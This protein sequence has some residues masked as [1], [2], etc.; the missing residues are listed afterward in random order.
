MKPDPIVFLAGLPPFSSLPK[1]ELQKIK[2]RISEHSLAQGTTL[3]VQ[4]KTRLDRI[5]I[6]K[7]GCLQLYYEQKGHKY[8]SGL[9]LPGEIY[10][11][12][13][14]LTN[15]GIS[16]RTVIAKEHSQLTLSKKNI[17]WKSVGGLIFFTTILSRFSVSGCS[18]NPM[19]RLLPQRRRSNFFQIPFRFLFCRK[20]RWKG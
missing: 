5:H 9:I 7:T 4:G 19:P 14:L 10:G 20:R 15:S 3:A 1:S 6:V 12:I 16:V 2:G 13:S 8:L 11:G 17:S 18:T